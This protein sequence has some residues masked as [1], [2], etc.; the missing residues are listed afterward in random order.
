MKL[1]LFLV[2]FGL[3]VVAVGVTCWTMIATGGYYEEA[4]SFQAGPFEYAIAVGGTV[5][6]GGLFVVGLIRMIVKH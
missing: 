4:G 2:L 5:L 6:G 1:D 3:I